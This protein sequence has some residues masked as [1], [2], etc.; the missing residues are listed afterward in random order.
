MESDPQ[1]ES[2]ELSDRQ[3]PVLPYL[4]M[5]PPSHRPRFV[6]MTALGLYFR[7][8]PASPSARG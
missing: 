6:R 3:L 5:A 1:P 7:V 2:H 8:V 4:V